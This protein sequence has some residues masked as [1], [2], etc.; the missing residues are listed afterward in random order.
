MP[1]NKSL[2]AEHQWQ[3]YLKRV[4]LN[5]STMHPTQKQE[6]KRAFFGAIGQLL[7]LQ[8]DEIALLPENKG[9]KVLQ[10]IFNEVLNFW[11]TE[12]GQSN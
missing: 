12:V 11:Q 2:T 3:E 1:K 8:R 10:E 5:E 7:V 6:T 9:A 4:G